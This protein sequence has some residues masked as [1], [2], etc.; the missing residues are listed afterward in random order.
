[1]PAGVEPASTASSRNT[2]SGFESVWPNTMPPRLERTPAPAP[3]SASTGTSPK[4][5]VG[6]TATGLLTWTRMSSSDS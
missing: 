6:P 2:R 1:M 5:L 4:V 3:L